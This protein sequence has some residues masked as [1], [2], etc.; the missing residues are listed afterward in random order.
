[1]ADDK[2]TARQLG[3]P[4][5][6]FTRPDVCKSPVAPVPYPII[7]PLDTSIL[8]TPTVRATSVPTFTLRSRVP[9]VIG[10]E[11]GIGMGVQSGTFAGTGLTWPTGSSSTVRAEKFLLVR[12]NDP[13]MMNGG[14]TTGKLV[15]QPG[16]APRARIDGL[17]RPTRLT[18]PTIQPTPK[19]Q[20][21]LDWAGEKA[22]NAWNATSNAAGNAW[23]ATSNAAGQA[24]DGTKYYAGE[25]Y[26]YGKYINN[27]YKVVPRALGGL[28]AVGGA[29]EMAL[30]GAGL[31]APTGITQVAGGVAVVHGFDNTSTGLRQLW[32]GE[33]TNTLTHDAA[34]GTAR[35]LGASEGT[36]DA[37]GNITDLTAGVAAPA[38][39]AK[40]LISKEAQA[41]AKQEAQALAKQEAQALAKKEAE[42]V[43]KKEAEAVAKK[44]AEAV[45]KKEAEAAAKKEAEA[46]AK[47]GAD[48]VR[49]LKK[50]VRPDTSKVKYPDDMSK[51]KKPDGSWD[52]PGNKGFDGVPKDDVLKPGSVIDRFGG[53]NGS[54]F[55]PP[56]TPFEARALSPDSLTAPYRSFEVLRPLPVQSG[57]IA[58]AFGMPGGGTQFL[59]GP[60][61]GDLLNPAQ[62]GGAFLREI[63]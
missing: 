34:A 44:E 30:G 33:Y 40:G 62:P 13:F 31:A 14:N 46:A 25:A 61:L 57:G 22:G 59:T 7:A 39:V 24:W 60:K 27:E 52:W 48:G 8:T 17:G 29:G 21:W 51:Y 15:Y 3:V 41:L 50:P 4:V 49:V 45:A 10:D 26:E 58:P 54:Y 36:A 1:M 9:L 6:V 43:A 16:G 63:F 47:E 23:D 20:G 56:G 18:N 5:V 19:E 38:T 32:T 37:V 28:Q 53:N 55:S 2:E 12:H 35:L 42:A 11:A